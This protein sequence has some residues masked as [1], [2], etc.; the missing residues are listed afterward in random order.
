MTDRPRPTSF[1]RSR[2]YFEGLSSAE[3]EK[4][5]RTI[6]AGLASQDG[7]SHAFTLDT[8]REAVSAYRG[9]TE[10]DVRHN[11]RLFLG[12]VAPLATELGI[13]LAI[14]PDDPPRR[15]FGLPRIVSTDGDIQHITGSSQH[16]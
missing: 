5:T 2:R 3:R 7:S 8:F 9:L 4:L 6:L 14:H 15:L 11:L 12:E 10:D 16:V 13:C 1:Q